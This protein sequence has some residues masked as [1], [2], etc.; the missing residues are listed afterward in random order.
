MIEHIIFDCDGVLIDT[1]MVAAEIAV[2][3]LHTQQV[4]ITVEEFIR[5]HTG[6][7]FTGILNQLREEKQL[8][9]NLNVHSTM[10]TMEAEIRSNMRPI[11]GVNDML[12]QLDLPKSVVSNSNIDY[13]EDALEK[14]SITHHFTE[15]IFSAELVAHAKPSPMVYQFA[16]NNLGITADQVVAIEDSYTGVQ[17][18]ISAGIPTIGFLGGSH[19]L[20]G[21][22][23]R[24]QSLG[25]IGLAKDHK[26]LTEMLL[27]L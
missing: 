9:A 21:H 24:L 27:D 7:T 14:F 11:G 23:E 6:K 20:D 10:L 16:L 8:P 17:A 2:K 4:D 1:E 22:G 13:V 3:W 26:E 19:I 18:A 25:V 5:D 12:D 15:T